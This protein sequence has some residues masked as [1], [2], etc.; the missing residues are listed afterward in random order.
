MALYGYPGTEAHIKKHR[1]LILQVA[2]YRQEMLGSNAS[3]KA[4]FTHFFKSWMMHHILE[5]DRKY[6]EFLNAKGVY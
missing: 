4:S 1:K 2:E 5:E 3:N 6:G